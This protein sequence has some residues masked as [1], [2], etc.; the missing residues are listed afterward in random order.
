[1]KNLYFENSSQ[2]WKECETNKDNFICSI[3]PKGTYIKDASSQICENVQ[4]ENLVVMKI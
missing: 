4:L 2:K 1:M 3:C